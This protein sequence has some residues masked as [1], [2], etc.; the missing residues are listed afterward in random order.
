MTE[1]LE[2]IALCLSVCGHVGKICRGYRRCSEK[3]SDINKNCK[4]WTHKD[5]D[6]ELK[7]KDKDKNW[8]HKDKGKNWT[9]KDKDKELTHK[10]EDENLKLVLEESL[11]ITL[12]RRST[13]ME[14]N[15]FDRQTDRH[16]ARVITVIAVNIARFCKKNPKRAACASLVEREEKSL[17]RWHLKGCL[18]GEQEVSCDDIRL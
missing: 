11:R 8:T 3:S 5:K 12:G 13:S 15:E 1:K 2:L 16:S 7:H 10:G 14:K 18:S 6:K 17:L 4:N 9:Y